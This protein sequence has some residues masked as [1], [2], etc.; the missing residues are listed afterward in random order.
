VEASY[1]NFAEV[2]CHMAKSRTRRSTGAVNTPGQFA[3]GVTNNPGN[4]AS[5]VI[6]YIRYD[7]RCQACDTKTG[8]CKVKVSGYWQQRQQ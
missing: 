1:E 6:L 7:S 2:K 3:I 4:Q 5:P 8:E